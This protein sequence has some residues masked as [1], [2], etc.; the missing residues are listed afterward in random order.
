MADVL[1]RIWWL[2]ALR[3]VAAVIFGILALAYPGMTLVTLVLFFGAYVLVDGIASV[4]TSITNWRERDDH[5]LMLLSGIAGIGIGIVT[6]RTPELTALILL[7]Y[8]AAWALVIGVIQVAAAIRLRKEIE[9]E[10]WLAA[11][12][13]LSILFAFALWLFPGAGALSLIWLIGGYAIVFGVMLIA[14]SLKLRGWIQQHG[15]Q[16]TPA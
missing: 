5:W 3:G 2:A 9:G 12:G 13:I 1:G 14:L 11:S 4:A 15:P 8:I 16:A 7:M 6:F 10:L